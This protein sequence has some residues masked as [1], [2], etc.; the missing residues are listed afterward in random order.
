MVNSKLIY[1]FCEQNQLNIKYYI[2]YNR[3]SAV[4]YTEMVLM[5]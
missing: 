1:F 4:I 2:I 3:C 5:F